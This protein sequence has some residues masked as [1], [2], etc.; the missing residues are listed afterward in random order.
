MKVPTTEVL[1]FIP[2]ELN[3]KWN[4]YTNYNVQTCRVI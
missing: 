2:K 3:E 4:S 1:Y